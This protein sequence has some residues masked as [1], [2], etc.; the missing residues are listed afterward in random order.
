M[1]RL[2]AEQWLSM[3]LDGELSPRR[4][5]KLDAYL[6]AHPELADL[7]KEWAAIGDRYREQTVEPAQTPE[8]AWQ[9]VQRLIRLH[10][11]TDTPQPQWRPRYVRIQLAGLAVAALVIGFGFWRLTQLPPD[12]PF[13]AIAEADRTEVEWVETDLPDAMSMVYE[14]AD[15]GLTVIWVLVHDNGEDDE[16]AG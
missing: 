15:T 6:A 9:D 11:S 16:H 1:N 7:Q 10:K 8:A 3:A 4:R 5:A 13:A 12:I 2:K 14:D